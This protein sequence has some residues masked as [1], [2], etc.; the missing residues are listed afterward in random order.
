MT[1][2]L[3]LIKLLNLIVQSKFM[4]PVGFEPT[5]SGSLRV[6]APTGH[7]ISADPFVIT[8]LEP[9]ALPDYAT[10]PYS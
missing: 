1:K 8:P 7:H 3:T 9:A 4:G 2:I 5:T 6:S 10:A